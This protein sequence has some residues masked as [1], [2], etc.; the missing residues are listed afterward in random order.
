M[1]HVI[2]AK[3]NAVH[4]MRHPTLIHHVLVLWGINKIDSYKSFFFYRFDKPVFG[5]TET[6]TFL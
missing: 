6:Y 3:T 2:E 4:M 1:S 5:K